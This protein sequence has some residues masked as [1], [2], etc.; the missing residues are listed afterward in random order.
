[1]YESEYFVSAIT[2]VTW[3]TLTNIQ[4]TIVP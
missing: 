4:D 1:M 3:C 2:I